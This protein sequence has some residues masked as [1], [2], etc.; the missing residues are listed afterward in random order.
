MPI[1][2]I[3]KLEEENK[4]KSETETDIETKE[5]GGKKYFRGRHLGPDAWYDNYGE[6]LTENQNA[7]QTTEFRKSGLN[8]HGQ[9]HE[10]VEKAK[11][12]NEKLRIRESLLKQ[13][14]A[15]DEEIKNTDTLEIKDEK[16]KK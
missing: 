2:D 13:L 10:Q 3:K 11:R 15:V 14:A 5:V 8:Q 12:K 6:C 4:K 9:T 16:K 1:V 7:K